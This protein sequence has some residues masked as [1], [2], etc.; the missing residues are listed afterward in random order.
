M[1]PEE[2][3]E[4]LPLFGEGIGLDSIDALELAV[5]LDKKYGV[6]IKSGD[7]RNEEIFSSLSSLAQF[8]SE[9]RTN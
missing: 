3:D 1:S 2:I 4:N 8:V 6:K 5:I 7:S 9:N